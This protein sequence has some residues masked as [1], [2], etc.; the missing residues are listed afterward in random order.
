MPL[1]TNNCLE[2]NKE[3]KT[4]FSMPLSTNKEMNK[5]V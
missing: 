2:M 1:S 5:F 3:M 4:L